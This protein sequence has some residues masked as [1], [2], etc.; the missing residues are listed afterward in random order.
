MDDSTS[1]FIANLNKSN[2]KDIEYVSAF[3]GK[4]IKSELDITWDDV[5]YIIAAMMIIGFITYLVLEG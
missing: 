2:E 4:R 3:S 1:K 5:F